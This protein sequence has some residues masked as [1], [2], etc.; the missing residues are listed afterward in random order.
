MQQSIADFE[1]VCATILQKAR[2]IAPRVIPGGF[3]DV[4]DT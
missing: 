4:V 1:Q 3:A 2:R